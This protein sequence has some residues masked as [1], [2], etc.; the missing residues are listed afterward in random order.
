MKFRTFTKIYYS[1]RIKKSSNLHFLYLILII[2]IDYLIN[3]LLYPSKKK[4]DQFSLENSDLFHKNLNDLFMFFNSDKGETFIN[5]YVKPIKKKEKI[6]GHNYHEYYESFFNKIKN[7]KLK[8]LELGAFKGNAAAALYFYFRYAT[9]YSGDIFPDLFLYESKRIKNFNID[10]GSRKEIEEKILNHQDDFDI[11]IEDA[12]HYLK[13]QILSLFM[14]F[15]KL[16]NKGIFVIEELDFPDNRKD[17]NPHNER[18]SLREILHDILNNKNF[19]SPH[20][21]D[22]EKK[23]FLENFNSIKIYKGNFNEIAF[24]TKK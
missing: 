15:P 7:Q 16:N 22:S 18:P 6:S 14:I 21:S 23:Y 1:H 8:I 19:N 24:I 9:I 12:G 2:P 13:D 5:Q 4:L 20:I 3:K 10:T 17:M 11:I